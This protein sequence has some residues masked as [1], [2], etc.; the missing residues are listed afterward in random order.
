MVGAIENFETKVVEK[1]IG[2][3][4]QT[5]QILY[6]LICSLLSGQLWIFIIVSYFK[7]GQKGNELFQSIYTKIAFGFC[8]FSLV[9]VPIYL[10]Y[11]HTLNFEYNNIMKVFIPTIQT[12]LVLQVMFFIF[13]LKFRKEKK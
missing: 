1:V 2:Y 4:I 12:G 8:W 13:C 5:P 7:S 3:I 11:F 10:L 6:T 9:L